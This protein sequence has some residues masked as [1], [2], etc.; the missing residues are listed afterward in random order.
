M[1]LF[2]ITGDD[3][4][5]LDGIPN[6]TRDLADGDVSS[7]TI[8]NDL[9]NIVVGK[10]GNVIYAKDENGRRFDMDLRVLKGSDSDALLLQR[11][12][13]MLGNFAKTTF[14]TGTFVKKLGDGF[15]NVQSYT[16]N[17]SGA[18]I[19][20]APEAMS[21]TAGDTNQSVTIYSISGLI[22]NISIG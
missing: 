18:V 17:L 21:N 11:Y 4:I 14:L 9:V 10:N 16:Y 19:R 1:A 15:G 22:E 13:N 3:Q 12:Q 5:V 2:S 8:P 6:L 7:I 20:K